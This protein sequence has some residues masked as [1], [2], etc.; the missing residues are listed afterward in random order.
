MPPVTAPSNIRCTV[1][2]KYDTN[3]ILKRLRLVLHWYHRLTR[4]NTVLPG[5]FPPMLRQSPWQYVSITC[6]L[7]L[8]RTKICSGK[9]VREALN[10]SARTMGEVFFVESMAGKRRNNL[11]I[12]SFSDDES[13]EKARLP[14]TTHSFRVSL[15]PDSDGSPDD[16]RL[17]LMQMG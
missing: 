10:K 13:A 6:G 1:Y 11:F 14:P 3:C 4:A 7:F 5:I 15:S 8:A 2:M 9:T 12:S 16:F 17:S